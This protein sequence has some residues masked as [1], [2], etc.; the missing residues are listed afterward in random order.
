MSFYGRAEPVATMGAGANWRL[1]DAPLAQFEAL[2]LAG[3]GL[4]QIV[5]EGDPARAFERC[6]NALRVMFEGPGE[7]VVGVDAGFDNDK[8][9]GLD[10]TVFVRHPDHRRFEHILIGN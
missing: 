9:L 2:D 10:Q 6:Q 8:R 1:T 5:E 3:R 4:W 7:T